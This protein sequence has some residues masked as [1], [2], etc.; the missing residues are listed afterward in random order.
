MSCFEMF[1]I[2]FGR[3]AAEKIPQFLAFLLCGECLA[4]GCVKK[5]QRAAST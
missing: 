4:L 2:G 5:Q 1:C 3:F